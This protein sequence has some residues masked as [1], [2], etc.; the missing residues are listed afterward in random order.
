MGTNM[1]IG[2][3]TLGLALLMA[4]GCKKD[5]NALTTKMTATINGKSWVSTI[6]VTVKND[7]GFIIT[8]TQ[9]NSSLVTSEL[10]IRINGFTSGTYNVIA[11]SNNCLAT[12]TPDVTNASK[13]YV[14]ATGIVT[15]TDINTSDKTISGTFE[16]TCS[17]LS[18]EMVPITN[19]SFTGL[20]YTETSGD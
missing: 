11:S 15:V 16:F 17:N 9:V 14:S 10:I 5:D 4:A 2:L 7:A 3:I 12:Y 18:L 1:K 8:A 6:R 20:K 19:G 13:S